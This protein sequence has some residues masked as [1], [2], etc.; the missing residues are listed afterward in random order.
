MSY[1]QR[2]GGEAYG[3]S[4]EPADALEGEDCVGGIGEAFVLGIVRR[5]FGREG[6]AEVEKRR[7]GELEEEREDE[8]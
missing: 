1:V 8:P 5:R 2:D 4:C 6:D 7:V 3:F